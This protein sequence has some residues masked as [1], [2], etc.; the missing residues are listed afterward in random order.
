MINYHTDLLEALSKVKL[1]VYYEMA[2]HRMELPCISYMELN[3]YAE[4]SGDT[5]GYSRLSFQIKVWSTKLEELQLYSLEI[6]KALRPL[7]LIRTAS[8]EMYN[9]DKSLLQKIL[10]YSCLGYEQF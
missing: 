6:D 9:Q 2:L 7:G 8:G 5:V 1:P 3:N 4:A 10:T